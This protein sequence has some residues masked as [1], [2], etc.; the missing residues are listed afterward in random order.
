MHSE[1]IYE[2]FNPTQAGSVVVYADRVSAR[3]AVHTR[4]NL[5][6]VATGPADIRLLNGTL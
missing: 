1:A 5:Q 4:T 6:E 3:F 2:A